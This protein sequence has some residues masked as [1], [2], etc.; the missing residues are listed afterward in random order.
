MLIIIKELLSGGPDL[1]GLGPPA[2]PL[3]IEDLI[4][5]GP[6]FP[7]LPLLPLLVLLAAEDFSTIFGI[8]FPLCPHFLLLVLTQAAAAVNPS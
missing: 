1:S 6:Q 4:E 2:A 5:N 3:N 8:I 7:P